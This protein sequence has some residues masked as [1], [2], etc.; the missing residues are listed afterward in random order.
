MGVNLDDVLGKKKE[1]IL[2]DKGKK[3]MNS[4]LIVIAIIVVIIVIVAINII[5]S[6]ATKA[7]KQRVLSINQEVNAISLQ[8]KAY[9]DK[10]HSSEASE[11][12]GYES[13]IGKP[14]ES[15]SPD[16]IIIC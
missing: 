1:N 11:R 12:Q 9:Y 5:K 10:Q 7:A 8:I 2:V 3:Q 13:Y 14:Q 16:K 15:E 6:N 4:L